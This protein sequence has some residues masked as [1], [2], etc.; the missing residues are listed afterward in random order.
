MQDGTADGRRYAGRDADERRA[1][2]RV[3][4]VAA[5]L[6]LFGS[7]GYAHVSVK[8]V[9]ERARLT[10]RYFYESFADR[11]ALLTAVYDDVVAVVRDRTLA[12]VA[13]TAAD[14]DVGDVAAAGLGAFVD[15]LTGDERSA[16]VML[17]EVV[18]VSP[19]LEERRAG[20]IHAFADLVRAV[21]VERFGLPA[22]EERQTLAAVALVGAANQLLVDWVSAPG[23]R[24]APELV[25]DVLV[26]LFEATF[27][28]LAAG[29][30]T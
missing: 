9:C 28:R 19:A 24:P 13:A 8:Q 21:A 18:G 6:D 15:C 3:A 7:Q 11:E 12:A 14:G 5:G 10:Q 17:L 1:A 29:S 27:D 20:V 23:D 16:R 25:R 2:R 30:A 26:E 4:L 22:D